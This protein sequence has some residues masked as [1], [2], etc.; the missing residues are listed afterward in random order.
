L[1][2][3]D[4]VYTTS[5]EDYG[6]KLEETF[7]CAN[8]FKKRV[9]LNDVITIYYLESIV[10]SEEIQR[11]IIEPLQQQVKVDYKHPVSTEK[12]SSIITSLNWKQGSTYEEIETG[13]LNGFTFIC[14]GG[15][16]S[17]LL[18][19]TQNW[20]EKSIEEVYGERSLKGPINGMTENIQSNINLIRNYLRTSE[21]AIEMESYGV[22]AKTNVSLLY[23]KDTVDYN[24]LKILKNRLKTVNVNYLLEPRVIEDAIEGNDS[25]PVNLL[26][27]TDR[28]DHTTSALTEGKVILLVDGN[29]NA[30]I[31]PSLFVDFFQAADDY[32]A[33][34]G[35]FTNRMIRIISFILAIT[36]PGI[37]V[38]L[39]KY[40][41]ND[42][43][44]KLKEIL[45]HKDEIL[46][47]FIEMI[48]LLFLLRILFDLS[49]RAPK[50]LVILLSFVATI[51]IGET[52]VSGKL[53]HPVGLV[54]ASISTF[55]AFSVGLR[56]QVGM[57][58]STRFMY[59]SVGYFFNFT[60][61]IILSTALIL[62]LTNLKSVGVPFLSPII[63]FNP[64][65]FQDVF[66]RG[67]LKK[68][69]NKHH[70]FPNLPSNKK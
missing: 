47:T 41:I 26:I 42:F 34:T 43:S 45:F 51:S 40:R 17:G 5:E 56:G 23:L 67:N 69:N 66:I 65:E 48:L 29:P 53:I 27:R 58:A 70:S 33:K 10:K 12:V 1:F 28:M 64:K 16:T 19:A 60:G 57:I 9:I 15:K 50:S 36:L 61:L 32:H 63:P 24:V 68:L 22:K 46:P 2:E 44:K 59:L 62:Y 4:K 49:S 21:L 18:V 39:K 20:K 3:G 8:D 11:F 54:V 31:A 35:R 14:L 30:I 13:L 38:T 7:Q 52:A 37:Y 6:K 25:G 55:L